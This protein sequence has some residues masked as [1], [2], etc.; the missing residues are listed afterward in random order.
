MVIRFICGSIPPLRLPGAMFNAWVGGAEEVLHKAQEFAN[1]G[2]LCFAATLLNHAVFAQP[3]NSQAKVMLAAIYEKLG[4][5][6][7]NGP[8]RNFYLS[9]AR[10][11]RGAEPSNSL[12]NDQ[13][14]I[15]NALSL[16][17]LF[18]SIAV[19][20]DGREAQLEN[21]VIDIYVSDREEHCRL[22]VSNGA[23]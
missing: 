23:L 10:E 14:Q 1:E 21:F 22:L 19:R 3:Q 6:S 11:L 13:N 12:L 20:L 9:G 8:W 15:T 7:E 17:H 4:Y 5:G 16:H 18:G 2:D